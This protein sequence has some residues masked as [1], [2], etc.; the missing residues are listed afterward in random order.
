[1]ICRCRADTV[2]GEANEAS[3]PARARSAIAAS[4][5][6]KASRTRR[7]SSD[8]VVPV[9]EGMSVFRVRTSPARRSRAKGCASHEEELPSD[10][11]E[12]LGTP[13]ALPDQRVLVGE[14]TEPGE[15]Q[16]TLREVGGNGDPV[17]R[18]D[19]GQ[20]RPPDGAV[21]MDMKMRLRQRDEIPHGPTIIRPAR[22]ERDAARGCPGRGWGHGTGDRVV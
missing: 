22:P 17:R 15:P 8:R 13:Q 19:L 6:P 21:E 10:P 2:D 7:Y 3:T 5:S 9:I 16:T 20:G 12:V 18:A 14:L 1:M 11:G 4:S